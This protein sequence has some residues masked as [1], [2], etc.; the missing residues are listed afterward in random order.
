MPCQSDYL[1]PTDR[2]KESARVIELLKEVRGR[3]F[4]HEHPS[5]VYGVPSRLDAD[6]QALCR[7]CR[8]HDVTKQSLELQLWWQRHQ[9]A[10]AARKRREQKKKV[11]DQARTKA[12]AKLTQ[13][14]RQ[15]LGLE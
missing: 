6:T 13:R 7:W 3:R 5:D 8:T 1:E 2:E 4:N 12:L 14:E 9:K 11:E 10:D 15:L